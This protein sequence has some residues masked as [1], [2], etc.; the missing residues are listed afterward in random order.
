MES[1]KQT[2]TNVRWNQIRGLWWK[3]ARDKGDIG[4]KFKC[5]WFFVIIEIED[6]H[7]IF[8]V[9]LALKGRHFQGTFSKR[10]INW[11]E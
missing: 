10:P 8:Y 6:I 9:G 11:Y 5:W 4:G 2:G 7:T 1:M 3:I